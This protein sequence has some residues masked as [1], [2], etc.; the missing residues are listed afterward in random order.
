[1]LLPKNLWFLPKKI[2][3]FSIVKLGD[4]KNFWLSLVLPNWVIEKFQSL[5]KKNWFLPKKL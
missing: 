4:Q 2:G 3:S 1:L 5:P